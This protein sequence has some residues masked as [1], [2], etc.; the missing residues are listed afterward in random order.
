MRVIARSDSLPR[1]AADIF[2]GVA[3]VA[4]DLR[5]GHRGPLHKVVFFRNKRDL[6]RAWRR[7]QVLRGDSPPVQHMGPARGFVHQC[8]TYCVNLETC[9][10]KLLVDKR[11][12]SIICL[13]G[14]GIDHEVCA[15]EA[16]HAAMAHLR[17]VRR[18]PDATIVSMDDEEDVA[19]PL[20]WIASQ[21]IRFAAIEGWLK[22]C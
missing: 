6:G 1:H 15:H 5:P 18:D 19:Y 7:L 8:H 4:Y 16:L 10:E 17:R 12:A 20:G 22:P 2:P 13:L 11:Y 3:L 14:P 21:L 9:R